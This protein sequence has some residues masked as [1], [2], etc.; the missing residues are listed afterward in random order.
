M[1]AVPFHVSIPQSAIDDLRDRLRNTRWPERETVDDWSQG[2]PLAYT[3]ELCRYWAD[4]YDF[5]AFQQRL[6]AFPQF[7]T[8]IDGLDIHFVHAR[9]P[10]EG[11]FPLVLTHGWPGSVVEFL[12]VIEPLTNPPDP[13]DAF[14]VVAPSLPGYGF[15][16]KPSAPGWD[17]ER[18]GR[19]WDALMVSLGYERYGAQGGDWGAMVTTAIAEQCAERVAG[20]HV[21]MAVVALGE[22]PM[23]DLTEHEQRALARIAEHSK[24]GMGYSSEQSTRPQTLGYGLTD[25]AAGQCAWIAEKFWEWTDCDGHP[26]RALTKDEMLDNISV[27]WFT[28]TA[29]SSARL[30]WESFRRS[31]VDPVSVPSGISVYPHEIIQVSERWARTRFHDLR[32][33]NTLDKGGHFAAFEQPERFVDEVRSFFR[34]VR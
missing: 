25:S 14:H 22:A 11:A 33:F 30:Y 29:A 9:S 18:I 32:Y 27:Y 16:A 20:V 12:K 8:E 28:A 7:T 2:I 34:L 15:S 6:T 3:Q 1:S 13:A 10:H 23:D 17:I 31:H 24:S 4:Q 21:N 26:E 5:A 19:A